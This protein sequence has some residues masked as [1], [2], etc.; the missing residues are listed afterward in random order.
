MKRCWLYLFFIWPVLIKS[1]TVRVHIADAGTKEP[2]ANAH[3]T[4]SLK[5]KNTRTFFVSDNNGN[6][7]VPPSDSVEIMVSHISY[8]FEKIFYE[9]LT[10]EIVVLLTPVTFNLSEFV[11]TAQSYVKPQNESVYSIKTI[12]AEKISSKGANTVNEAL[13]NEMNMRFSYRPSFGSNI[14]L[15]GFSGEQVNIMI[16]GVSVTGRLN[17]NLDLQQINL[18]NTNKIEVLQ[19]PVSVVYGSNSSG[20]A[21]NLI[22]SKK[23]NK[24][25]GIKSGMYYESVGQYNFSTS[26]YLANTKNVFSISVGRNFFGGYSPLDTSRHKLWLQREQYFSDA[27]YAR[28]FKKGEIS[29]SISYFNEL[30]K[31]RGNL[32]APYYKTAFDT[33]YGTQRLINRVNTQWKFN[34]TYKADLTSAFSVYERN[35]NKY[36]RDLV[37]L[38]SI[39]VTSQGESDTSVTYEYF[40]R[41]IFS[42]NKQNA[43]FNFQAGAEFLYSELNANRI[44]NNRAFVY[45]YAFFIN[46]FF[47]PFKNNKF[48]INPGIRYLQNNT[49]KAPL[50]YAVNF[51]MQIFNEITLK[52]SFAKG[53]RTPS[54]K[55]RY[56]DFYFSESIQIYG[57]ANLKAETSNHIRIATDWSKSYEKNA[58]QIELSVFYNHLTNM[59]TT[60]QTDLTQWNYVN[61]G[62]FYSQGYSFLM[63]NKSKYIE[64]SA[65]VN[66]TGFLF[67]PIS[68]MQNNNFYFS[69][70]V[71]CNPTFKLPKHNLFFDVQFKYTGKLVSSYLGKNNEVQQNYIAD[72]NMIDCSLRKKIWK[73]KLTVVAGAKNILN[74]TSVPIQ[75]RLY[76]YSVAKDAN[77]IP[78]SW[79]RTGF[80]S[81]LIEL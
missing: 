9:H 10:S 55:E 70:E 29:A 45:D 48:T 26:T 71:V 23:Y 40:V 30:M 37:T 20:G 54:I 1:Q 39:P 8:V 11:I 47:Y 63:R 6:I 73:E 17:G 32:R 44:E 59:I 3:I 66:Y 24:S 46:S 53:F 74:I 72:Y 49:Y 62:N 14:N 67:Q 75:G 18:N 41:P 76:G 51:N 33:Y 50:I 35:R 79:G 80:V 78:I 22:S 19:G 56:L 42:S 52:G 57:N 16:D 60:A 77:L 13:S 34:E 12:D 58:W 27:S 4:L 2:V 69:P 36:F 21:I 81:L 7:F 5:Q 28:L 61:V 68:E 15:Q 43:Y 25:F 38:E 31:D 65:G 64:L